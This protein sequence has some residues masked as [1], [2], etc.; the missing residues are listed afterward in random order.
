MRAANL[1]LNGEF[2]QSASLLNELRSSD[3]LRGAMD[4][5]RSLMVFLLLFY[6]K[7]MNRPGLRGCG[8][9]PLRY[10]KQALGK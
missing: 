8:R 6:L 5:K 4:D 3:V 10:L 1:F 7:V 9:R 2:Q